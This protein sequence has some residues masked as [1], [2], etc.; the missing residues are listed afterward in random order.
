M[1]TRLKIFQKVALEAEIQTF[2][3]RWKHVMRYKMFS[4]GTTQPMGHIEHNGPRHQ[5]LISQRVE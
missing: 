5:W 2:I 4:F 1:I 3:G